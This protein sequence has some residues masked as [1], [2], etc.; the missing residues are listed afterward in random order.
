MI[1][2]DPAL[3]TANPLQVKGFVDGIQQA[4]CVTYR[5]HRPVYLTYVAAG[6]G[7][8]DGK[9]LGVTERIAVLHSHLDGEWLRE[10]SCNL[11]SIELAEDRPDELA[12]AGLAELGGSRE[13]L[14]RN[15]VENMLK[16]ERDF[17]VVDGSLVA[18]PTRPNVLGVVKTTNKKYL[19]DESVL[20]G[21]RTNWRSP[22]FIIPAGVQGCRAPRYS[23]YLRLH[24][25]SRQA[26]NFG[27]I[28]LET[29][30][31][32]LLE[33]LCALAI[34][35][36]QPVGSQDRRFD[37]HLSGVRAVEDLLRARKPSVF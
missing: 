21:L 29:F 24:D 31:L 37:R 18:R 6:C 15:L 11:P 25:A 20:W 27:L 22:R 2:S 10:I 17:L 5:G 8:A 30:E 12:A 28:R 1:D 33:P 14:E 32:D 26:W 23:C 3:I 35:E 16:T 4:I 19:P 34:A 7:S 36:R 9:L 13:A